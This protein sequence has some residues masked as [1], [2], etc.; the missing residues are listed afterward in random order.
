MEG[1]VEKFETPWRRS[2]E[3]SGRGGGK[4]GGQEAE[5]L[6]SENRLK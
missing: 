3:E 6:I 4:S 5:E 1:F 2:A